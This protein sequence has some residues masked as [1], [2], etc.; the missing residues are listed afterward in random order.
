MLRIILVAAILT[1]CVA[2]SARFPDLIR[3]ERTPAQTEHA[4][5]TSPMPYVPNMTS[6]R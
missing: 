3:T 6:A 5:E 4:A 1:A 2:V